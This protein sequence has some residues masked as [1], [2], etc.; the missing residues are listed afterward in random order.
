MVDEATSSSSAAVV[1]VVVESDGH[2]HVV[3]GLGFV[4]RIRVAAF[5]DDEAVAM[6]A[7][8]DVADH[9]EAAV[10]VETFAVV[11]GAL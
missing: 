8:V 9:K 11:G 10:K 6:A 3:G 5:A 4:L 1:V 2:P 7:V